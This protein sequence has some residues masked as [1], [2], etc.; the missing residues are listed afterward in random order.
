MSVD[1]KALKA[2]IA[3]ERIKAAEWV[4]A[5]AGDF[6]DSYMASLTSPP[7]RDDWF[8]K[9]LPDLDYEIKGGTWEDPLWAWTKHPWFSALGLTEEECVTYL[10]GDV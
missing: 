2:S 7:N 9:I 10:Q 4:A 5:D 6:P 1:Q 3:R 8:A